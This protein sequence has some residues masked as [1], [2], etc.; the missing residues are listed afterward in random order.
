MKISSNEYK[1]VIAKFKK[2]QITDQRF[3]MI[4]RVAFQ[5][6]ASKGYDLAMLK[7]GTLR[8]L[9]ALLPTGITS[10]VLH[11]V[12][13]KC[14]QTL[15][16]I[17]RPHLDP[18]TWP[19]V[20][21]NINNNDRAGLRDFGGGQ[22]GVLNDKA[23]SLPLRGSFVWNQSKFGDLMIIGPWPAIAAAIGEGGHG[24]KF[25]F[26]FGDIY[27]GDVNVE[28]DRMYTDLEIPVDDRGF[29]VTH[30]P[31]A[32]FQVSDDEG[33]V[34]LDP[35]GEM[36]ELAGGAVAGFAGAGA[37]HSGALEIADTVLS[38]IDVI[39]NMKEKL[40]VKLKA[41]NSNKDMHT[42][43]VSIYPAAKNAC[44]NTNTQE[45]SGA[46]LLHICKTLADIP[47]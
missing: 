28:F 24:L 23:M 9:I 14:K 3:K 26:G 47:V 13:T 33:E 34:V 30:I 15:L 32:A 31:G 42:F 4:E 38:S 46:E 12:R 36:V 7:E 45:L 6:L 22:L 40:G 17:A 35:R 5:N 43:V 19:K 18:N 39:A 37:S 2:L 25:E 44:H 41:G 20:F 8:R 1:H 11:K 10:P 16:H 27:A 21:R 29:Y